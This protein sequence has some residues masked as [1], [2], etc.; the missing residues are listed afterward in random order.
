VV[1]L[2]ADLALTGCAGIGCG[3]CGCA[4][5]SRWPIW[6]PQRRPASWCTRA[7]SD[8]SIAGR[9]ARYRVRIGGRRRAVVGVGGSSVG[10][11]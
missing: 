8:R 9:E 7:R 3:A 6:Q 1:E 2:S 11:V 4:V 5:N 10:V